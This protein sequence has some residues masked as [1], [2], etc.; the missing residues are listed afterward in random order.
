MLMLIAGAVTV[1]VMDVALGG[2]GVVNPVGVVITRFVAPAATGWNVVDPKLVSAAKTTGLVT[3]V[4]TAAIELVTVTFTVT[5]L[6]TFWK[7]W[8]VSVLGS[9]WP[10]AKV[11]GVSGEK[12]VVFK[13][14][15]PNHWKP[16]GVR[17]TVAVPLVYP[18]AV[19]VS[20][21]LPLLAKLWIEKGGTE[22]LPW[23]RAR[24]V[25][26]EKGP[27]GVLASRRLAELLVRVSV[28]L[29]GGAAPSPTD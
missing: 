14:P 3:I 23:V 16:E 9:S 27:A 11:S 13:L 10:A 29:V 28:R 5:P 20:W 24:L 22:G 17:F 2:L 18:A 19:A 25:D 7:A 21:A 26:C 4:P 6:R 8:S 15:I 12:V 1:T